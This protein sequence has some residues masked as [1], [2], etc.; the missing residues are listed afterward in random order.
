GR[1]PALQAREV[2]RVTMRPWLGDLGLS[3]H[4]NNGVYLS[5]M[6]VGRADLWFRS[7]FWRR[8]RAA[9]CYPVVAVATITYR[10]SLRRGQ[11]FVL[12]TRALAV[13]DRGL[14]LEQRFVVEGEIF[15]RAY[16]K[17]R[18]LATAGGGVSA[19]QLTEFV[20]ED[21]TGL[22]LEEW[23]LHWVDDVALP[24]TREPAPGAWD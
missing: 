21:L 14:F 23:M 2:S 1:Q 15:A 3:D 18:V 4:L 20:G 11:R 6:D 24:P 16:V 8:M 22:P 7:G 10:K 17:V 19:E 13:R 5:M 12:E 9:A